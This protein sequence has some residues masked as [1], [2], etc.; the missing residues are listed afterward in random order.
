M[1]KKSRSAEDTIQGH[2]DAYN[3]RDLKSFSSFFTPDAE[4]FHFPNPTPRAKGISGIKEIYGKLFQESPSL[5]AEIKNRI[6]MGSTVVDHEFVT[7]IRGGPLIEA[8]AIY[9]VKNGLIA[10]MWLIT[11]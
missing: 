3:K 7:G 6:V 4:M 1:T 9:E 10:R 5:R 8:T 11:L 2:L